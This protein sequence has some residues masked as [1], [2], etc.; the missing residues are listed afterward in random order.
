LFCAIRFCVS[1]G[2]TFSAQLKGQCP[3]DELPDL[4]VA[5]LQT[6][7]WQL[8]INSCCPADFGCDGDVDFSDYAVLANHWMNQGCI[9]PTWCG[10]A[11]INKS[12]SVD[13]Y[14]L[15]GFVEYWLA[16]NCQ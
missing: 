12:G 6:V 3:A 15:A 8:F 1:A 7:R 14:D 9:E 5:T 4:A 10:R 11:D 13:W 2:S 16:P